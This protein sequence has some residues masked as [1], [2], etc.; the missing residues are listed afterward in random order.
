MRVRLLLD[1]S[2]FYFFNK[3]YD[4]EFI[5]DLFDC[6]TRDLVVQLRKKDPIIADLSSPYI[7]LFE[8]EVLVKGEGGSKRRNKEATYEALVNALA[9]PC[10]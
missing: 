6:E 2:V 5:T 9:Q 7:Y 8:N 3:K 1:S 10:T 4:V